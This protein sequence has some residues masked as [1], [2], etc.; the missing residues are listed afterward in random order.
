MTEERRDWRELCA[1]VASEKDQSKLLELMEELLVVLDHL[2]SET[3]ERSASAAA[4]HGHRQDRISHASRT[5][6]KRS[7]IIAFPAK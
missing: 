7:S 5:A 1:A 6:R 2:E 3:T 4:N